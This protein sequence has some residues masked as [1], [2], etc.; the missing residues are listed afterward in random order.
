M[1]I[2]SKEKN[3][4][5]I[6]VGAARPDFLSISKKFRDIGWDVYSIEPNPYFFKY[7]KEKSFNIL[8]YACSFKDENNVDF[9][10]VDN[11]G[12]KYFI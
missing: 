2:F 12:A 4:V 5:F 6:E 1:C 8:P 3:G 11:K 7:Y 10:V 9:F